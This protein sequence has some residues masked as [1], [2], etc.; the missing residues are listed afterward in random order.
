[1]AIAT[2]SERYELVR[3]IRVASFFQSYEAM[4]PR[5]PG[6]FMLDVFTGMDTNAERPRAFLRDAARVS[7]LRHPHI[8]QM[9]EL[10]T[11]PDGTPIVVSELPPGQ[12]LEAWL[13]AGHVPSVRTVIKWIGALAEA[14]DA[15]HDAGVVHGA[16][17]A[18]QVFL[19]EATVGGLGLPKLKGFGL[20]WLRSPPS[21]VPA[22]VPALD[23]SQEGHRGAESVAALPV[24]ALREGWFPELR[25]RAGTVGGV[26]VDLAALA[27]LAEHLLRLS[28]PAAM[29]M[30]QQALGLPV[31]VAMALARASGE[32]GAPPYDSAVELARDLEAAA[33]D[34]PCDPDL[35]HGERWSSPGFRRRVPGRGRSALLTVGVAA[36]VV[37]CGVGTSSVLEGRHSLASSAGATPGARAGS[38]IAT[39]SIEARSV[40]PPAPG[41]DVGVGSG[42]AAQRS[43]R[44]VAAA[45]LST[46]QASPTR[47]PAHTLAPTHIPAPSPL[48]LRM[49]GPAPSQS[50][51]QATLVVDS[52]A[53]RLDG[54]GRGLRGSAEGDGALPAFAPTPA[55][56]DSSL[57]SGQSQHLRGRRGIVWS[58]GLGRLADVGEISTAFTGDGPGAAPAA[59]DTGR[60]VP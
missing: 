26:A 46:P 35:S 6:R 52:V 59:L 21:T 9:L 12:T 37:V 25:D 38:T 41:G 60:L 31:F 23:H 32:G 1:M 22:H 17:R 57:A 56:A 36:V 33:F 55:P 30:D 24:P 45:D 2:T 28:Q 51:F 11:M 15:A 44:L 58:P 19:V 20:E 3:R 29:A 18:D 27:S 43:P 34:P 42:S 39:G 48:P 14:V 40:Q 47:A 10:S 16:I 4:H 7:S 50:G 53:A 49:T 8:L 5:R 54:P 13:G